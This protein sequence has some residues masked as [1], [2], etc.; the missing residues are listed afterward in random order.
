MAVRVKTIGGVE[1]VATPLF[2]VSKQVRFSNVEIQ[3]IIDE[4]NDW[5]SQHLRRSVPWTPIPKSESDIAE[6]VAYRRFILAYL[7]RVDSLLVTDLKDFM[8]FKNEFYRRRQAWGP[9][10]RQ[11]DTL[12]VQMDWVR[13]EKYYYCPI[14]KEWQDMYEIMPIPRTRI[15]QYEGYHCQ[16]IR[17]CVRPHQVAFDEGARGRQGMLSPSQA[18]FNELLGMRGLESQ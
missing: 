17:G 13:F 8:A 6:N 16:I 4:S 5:E 10:T 14:A 15:H 3:V 1:V 2:K 9:K 18:R 11:M 12:E 7:R